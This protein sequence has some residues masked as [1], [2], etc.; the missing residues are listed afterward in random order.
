MAIVLGAVVDDPKW[1]VTR[2]IGSDVFL[3]VNMGQ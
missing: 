2:D 3:S 1:Q